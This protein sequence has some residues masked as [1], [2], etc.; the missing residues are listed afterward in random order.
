MLVRRRGGWDKAG[1]FLHEHVRLVDQNGQTLRAD[2][3]CVAFVGQ[4]QEGSLFVGLSTV[5]AFIFSHGFS[6]RK[7]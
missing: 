6:N 2:V 5:K 4:A 3:L 1:Q 7:S